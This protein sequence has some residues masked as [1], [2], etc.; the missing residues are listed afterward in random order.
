MKSIS[1]KIPDKVLNIP[2]LKTE[3]EKQKVRLK[4]YKEHKYK[5]KFF[6]CFIAFNTYYYLIYERS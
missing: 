2:K 6:H 1:Y 5:H 4:S 3:L